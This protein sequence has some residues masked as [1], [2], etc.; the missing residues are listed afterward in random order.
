M[1]EQSGSWIWAAALNY[2][3]QHRDQH[4][5]QSQSAEPL[6]WG[7]LL[8]SSP[9]IRSWRR[10]SATV[11]GPYLHYPFSLLTASPCKSSLIK[12]RFFK[13]VCLHCIFDFTRYFR[14]QPRRSFQNLVLNLLFLFWF[15]E[16]PALPRTRI[17]FPMTTVSWEFM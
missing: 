16:F 15:Y 12:F 1:Q 6:K 5:R 2:N 17:S 11:G 9:K 8:E 7:I 3:R 13:L 4:Q 10:N 14:C